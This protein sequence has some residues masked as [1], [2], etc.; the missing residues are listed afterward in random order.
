M[1][2]SDKKTHLLHCE[3]QLKKYVKKVQI[4]EGYV[5]NILMLVHLYLNM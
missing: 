1:D 2:L 5:E 4:F 3:N